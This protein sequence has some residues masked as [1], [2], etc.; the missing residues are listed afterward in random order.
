MY[1]LLRYEYVADVLTRRE[2]YRTEHLGAVEELHNQGI[3]TLA[4]AA[5]DPVDHAVFVFKTDDRS[6]IESF[7]AA[8]PY[9]KNGVVT[10][11]R[12]DP[13]NVVIGG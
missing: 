1:Y 6:V 10:S 2:P 4:G 8:D 7:V 12:I 9:V 13:W 11:W 3:V 5:G